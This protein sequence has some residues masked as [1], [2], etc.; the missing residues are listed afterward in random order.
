MK[1]TSVSDWRRP[2]SS[3]PSSTITSRG[4][5]EEPRCCRQALPAVRAPVK[6]SHC[7]SGEP[8]SVEATR[9]SAVDRSPHSPESMTR[10][11]QLEPLI[12]SGS[13]TAFSH[14][15]LISI[16]KMWLCQVLVNIA[17]VNKGDFSPCRSMLLWQRRHER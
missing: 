5:S 2:L 15:L 13:S 14:S 1:E 17:K 7:P 10:E 8:V 16:E 3:W 6:V 11:A 9:F 12:S 4:P